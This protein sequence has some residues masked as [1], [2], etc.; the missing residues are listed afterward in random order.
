LNSRVVIVNRQS[1]APVNVHRLRGLAQLLMNEILKL[2]NFTLGICLVDSPEM[3]RLNETFLH[4]PGST[5]VI[6]FD[7][8][9]ALLAASPANERR[10]SPVETLDGEIFICIDEAMAFARR[11]R[12]TWQKELARYVVHG[13]L[14]LCG[15]DDL[16]PRD[17]RLMKREENQLLRE[18]SRRLPPEHL[19]RLRRITPKTRSAKRNTRIH[20]RFPL[21]K[22]PRKPKLHS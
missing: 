18:L 16:H 6:T 21:S 14:H 20:P 4:H 17:R 22:R 1:A 12:T 5:D 9:R 13:V 10:G 7:Y 19:D 8:S 3:A 2:N 11:F 15:Y